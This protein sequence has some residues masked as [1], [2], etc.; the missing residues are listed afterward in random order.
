MSVYRMR[1]RGATRD[2]DKYAQLEELRAGW[3]A[4]HEDQIAEW[5]ASCAGRGRKQVVR[6]STD[7]PVQQ[8]VRQLLQFIAEW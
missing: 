5:N 4:E 6:M 1:A 7:Q 8:Q 2:S 3:L